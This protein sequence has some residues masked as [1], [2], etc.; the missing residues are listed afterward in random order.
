[1]EIDPTGLN[2]YEIEHT[3]LGSGPIEWRVLGPDGR[4]ITVHREV[5]FGTRT[6]ATQKNPTFRVGWAAAR[7]STASAVVVRGAS[8]AAFVGGLTST[9]LRNPFAAGVTGFSAG[10]TPSVALALR[11][12]GEFASRANQREVFLELLGASTET[13]NRAVRVDVWLN[14]TPSAAFTWGY[15][16][17]T[18]SGVESATPAAGTITI[19]GGRLLTSVPVATGSGIQIRLDELDLRLDTGDVIVFALSTAS[20]TA[21]CVLSATWRED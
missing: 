5:F 1:M 11:V 16:S 20:S 10:V 12:R 13:S 8:A 17:Q 6:T 21:S 7:G 4:F 9:P 3:H 18:L 19:S 15:V 14:P 2:V